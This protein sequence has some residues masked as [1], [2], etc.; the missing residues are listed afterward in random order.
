MSDWLR[1]GRIPGPD[2]RA[3]KEASL[4][5]P[6]SWKAAES[7]GREG[8]CQRRAEVQCGACDVRN[9]GANPSPRAQTTARSAMTEPRWGSWLEGPWSVRHVIYEVA[10]VPSCLITNEAIVY[11]ISQEVSE[12]I[13]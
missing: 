2:S 4:G 12:K 3:F 11:L 8:A 13:R 5:L 6:G 1:D 9:A 10:R 7:W